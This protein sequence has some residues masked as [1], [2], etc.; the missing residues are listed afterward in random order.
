MIKKRFFILSFIFSFLVSTTGLPM[1]YHFCH[2]IGK[3]SLTLCDVCNADINVNDSDCCS[4]G[5]S[6]S[7]AKVS[8][9]KSECCQTEFV[10]HKLQDEFVFDKTDKI[11]YSFSIVTITLPSNL[12]EP[13]NVYSKNIIISDSSPPFLIDSSLYLANS[14]LLI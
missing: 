3:T 12:F 5:H 11:N 6:D 14:V 8:L 4:D 10:Y 13:N 1:T 2:L 7:A 9:N